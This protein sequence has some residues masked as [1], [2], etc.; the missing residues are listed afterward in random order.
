MNGLWSAAGPV[1]SAEDVIGGISAIVWALTII[2]L[3]KYVRY[4][5]LLPD[6]QC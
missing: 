1:P 2:P 5:R 4:L 6:T 3:I